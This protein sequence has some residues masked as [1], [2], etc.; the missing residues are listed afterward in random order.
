MVKCTI[1]HT[2]DTQRARVSDPTQ[3]IPYQPAPHRS[4]RY[5]SA[6]DAV[7][8]YLEMRHRLEGCIGLDPERLGCVV[9][10]SHRPQN[11][12]LDR[13]DDIWELDR[14]WRIASER[15]RAREWRVWS[16][17]RVEGA[18]YRAVEGESKTTVGRIIERVDGVVESV[19][20]EQGL[21]IRAAVRR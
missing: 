19:L 2:R 17:V 11:P 18:A 16:Q 15:V 7:D 8:A 9:Q 13:I 10:I 3:Q 1:M 12:H 14:V 6:S 21:L 5:V 4:R 20:Y